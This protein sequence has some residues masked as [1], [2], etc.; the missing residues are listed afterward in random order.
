MNNS[1][2]LFVMTSHCEDWCLHLPWIPVKTRLGLGR[3]VSRR[4]GNSQ[5]LLG[6]EKL[7]DV[8]FLVFN[9]VI[10]ADCCEELSTR[11]VA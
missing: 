10:Y 11:T 6:V 1:L 3:D 4:E 7:N 2:A 9:P 8:L 5:F